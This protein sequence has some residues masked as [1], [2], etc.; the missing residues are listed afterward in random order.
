MSAVTTFPDLSDLLIWLPKLRR[1]S[2]T[3]NTH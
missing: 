3:L 2:Y 1:F